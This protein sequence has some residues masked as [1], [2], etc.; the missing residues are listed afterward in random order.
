MEESVQG[1]G[2]VALCLKLFCKLV[3]NKEATLEMSLKAFS[4]IIL[5]LEF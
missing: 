1:I 2:W 3:N 5:T 4:F